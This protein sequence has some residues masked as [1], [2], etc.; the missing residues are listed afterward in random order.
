MGTPIFNL[1][2][3]KLH[4]L[5]SYTGESRKNGH[6]GAGRYLIDRPRPESGE[7][8]KWSTDRIVPKWRYYCYRHLGTMEHCTYYFL[9]KK[10]TLINEC[11]EREIK[12]NRTCSLLCKNK[13]R[14]RRCSLL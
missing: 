13:R 5:Y 6:R 3:T 12:Y 2:V 4:P 14:R 9:I 8:G 10:Y 11:T 7:A 1:W